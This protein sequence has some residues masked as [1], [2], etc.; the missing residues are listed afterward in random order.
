MKRLKDQKKEINVNSIM[1]FASDP[2]DD[3][4]LFK[5]RHFTGE[6]R[7]EDVEDNL[8][9]DSVSHDESMFEKAY[10]CLIGDAF[11]RMVENRVSEIQY[12][13]QYNDEI[14]HSNILDNAKQIIRA[15]DA[16]YSNGKSSRDYLAEAQELVNSEDEYI[17]TSSRVLNSYIG[18]ISRRFVTPVI[19]KA[20]HCK[21]SWVDFNI[22][23]GLK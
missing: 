18:G 21:S 7:D 1:L 4:N 2:D 6:L 17:S 14:Y 23:Q 10:K 16:M 3:M 12:Y 20:S 22:A 8:Y 11:A 19:G 13:N 9:P 15:H 5:R